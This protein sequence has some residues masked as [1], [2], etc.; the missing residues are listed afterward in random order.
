MHYV[1]GNPP[2]VGA[3]M[4]DDEQRADME[5][6]FDGVKGAGV[7][8]YVA[9]WYF[10]AAEYMTAV[11]PESVEAHASTSSARTDVRPLSSRPTPSPRANR[12]ASCGA[13]CCPAFG[14]KIHFAHRT[15]AWSSEARGK[16]PVHC[17]II[18]FARFRER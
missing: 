18:G 5:Q 4:L 9:A 3:K 13:S 2:F 6:L 11:R 7:L 14:I 8:D 17:V 16:A 1:L 15:F 10:K 12:S